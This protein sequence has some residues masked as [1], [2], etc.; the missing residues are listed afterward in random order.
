MENLKTAAWRHALSVC[1]LTDKAIKVQHKNRSRKLPVKGWQKV[2]L[3]SGTIWIK[4]E[5]GMVLMTDEPP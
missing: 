1:I 3:P 4:E 2:S 5:A